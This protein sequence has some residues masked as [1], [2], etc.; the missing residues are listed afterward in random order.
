MS[1]ALIIVP[2]VTSAS[3]RS[4]LLTVETSTPAL[5]AE[6]RKRRF[7]SSSAAVPLAPFSPALAGSSA[8]AL[9]LSATTCGARSRSHF[10]FSSSA[11]CWRSSSARRLASASSAEGG[12]L[13]VKGGMGGGISADSDRR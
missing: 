4:S 9:A 7:G 2:A 10:F 6:A 3:G 11:S 8:A 13:P 1:T 12:C 5:P